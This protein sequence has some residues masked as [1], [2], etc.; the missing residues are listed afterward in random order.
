M[1]L[2]V[3]GNTVSVSLSP[4][5][6]KMVDCDF[7]Y[8]KSEHT[9][10]KVNFHKGLKKPQPDAK[11]WSSCHLTCKNLPLTTMKGNQI[12]GY[13]DRAKSNLS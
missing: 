8:K 11:G 3:K 12:L 1:H 4:F 9:I 2:K 10:I 7:V 13:S 6:S 5:P